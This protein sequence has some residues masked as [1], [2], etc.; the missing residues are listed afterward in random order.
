MQAVLHELKGRRIT[1][2]VRANDYLQL[3]LDEDTTLSVYN[4]ATFAPVLLE[5]DSL[6]GAQIVKI[7]ENNIAIM[8]EFDTGT[9]FTIDMTDGGYN[10]PEAMQ[11]TRMNQPIIIWN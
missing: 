8:L 4:K 7:M 10:G 9:T 5:T 1:S 11:L 2:V 6:V 3:Y